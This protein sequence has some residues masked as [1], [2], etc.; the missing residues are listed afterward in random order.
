MVEINS[1]D[2]KTSRWGANS[3]FENREEN[4]N[5]PTLWKFFESLTASEF[6]NLIHS[7]AP[8]AA[9]PTPPRGGWRRAAAGV[10]DSDINRRQW[11]N[12]ILSGNFHLQIEIEPSAELNRT[13]T[14]GGRRALESL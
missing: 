13:A 5:L 8:C 12:N 1:Y 14:P 10:G 7:K 2:P 6:W 4:S 11:T 3:I 9:T